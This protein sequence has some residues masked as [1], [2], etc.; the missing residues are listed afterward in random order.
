MNVDEL[1]LTYS[2]VTGNILIVETEA[3]W[4]LVCWEK[5]RYAPCWDLGDA[6]VTHRLS[7]NLE[8]EGEMLNPVFTLLGW[9]LERVDVFV[10]GEKVSEGEYRLSREDASRVVF[11]EQRLPPDVT[12]T[13]TG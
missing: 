1:D 2:G 8:A 7:F 10:D 13:L 11:V 12:I 3:P 4:R 6:W 9:E 5:A